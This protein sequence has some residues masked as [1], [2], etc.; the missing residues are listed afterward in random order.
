MILTKDELLRRLDALGQEVGD[1]R[2]MMV[3]VTEQTRPVDAIDTDA[4]CSVEFAQER[5][6]ELGANVERLRRDVLS[7]L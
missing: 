4:W 2:D 3:A 1:M 5:L 7:D 6:D